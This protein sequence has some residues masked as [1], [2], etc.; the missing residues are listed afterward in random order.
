MISAMIGKPIKSYGFEKKTQSCMVRPVAQVTY[1]KAA[2]NYEP[3]LLV[4]MTI[5]DVK[6]SSETLILSE[7]LKA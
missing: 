1:S 3:N 6:C 5:C 4:L 2:Y 7:T